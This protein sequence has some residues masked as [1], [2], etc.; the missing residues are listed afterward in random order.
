MDEIQK[1]EIITWLH[2]NLTL[3]QLKEL[4]VIGEDIKNMN[5]ESNRKR[6]E[7]GISK[8]EKQD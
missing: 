3:S 6:S 1:V 2:H 4:K 8:T 7:K 5:D